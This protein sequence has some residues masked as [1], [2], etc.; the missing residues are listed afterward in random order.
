M[1][2]RPYARAYACACTRVPLPTLPTSARKPERSA[3]A[4]RELESRPTGRAANP[5][6]GADSLHAGLSPPEA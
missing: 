4:S 5:I 1:S 6:D 2:R 3:A